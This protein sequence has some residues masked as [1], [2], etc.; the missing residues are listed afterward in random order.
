MVAY[1]MLFLGVQEAPYTVYVI[2]E[3]QREG[4]DHPD[5]LHIVFGRHLHGEEECQ[6]GN[7]VMAYQ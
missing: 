2:F 3:D 1:I 6:Y 5:K 7:P 4:E